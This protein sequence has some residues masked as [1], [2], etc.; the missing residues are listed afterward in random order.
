MTFSVDLRN[1]AIRLYQ[2]TLSMRGV[3]KTLGVSKSSIQRWLSS[4]PFAS[5]RRMVQAANLSVLACIDSRLARNPFLTGHQLAFRIHLET[6]ARVSLSTIY[7]FIKSL[8]LRRKRTSYKPFI[9]AAVLCKR[10]LFAN[11]LLLSDPNS[12]VSVDETAFQ[13]DMFPYA[14]YGESGKRLLAQRKHKAY[15]KRFSVI[16]AVSNSEVVGYKIVFGSVN[17]AVFADFVS[18]LSFKPYH[19]HLLMDNVAFHKTQLVQR[20][21]DQKNVESLFLSPYSPDMNLIELV[22]SKMKNFY[23]RL[24]DGDVFSRVERSLG[25]ECSLNSFFSH[26]WSVAAALTS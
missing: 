4:S 19:T 22:F 12:V 15:C 21:L 25:V 11:R 26:C 17:S 23:R 8:G 3:A 24:A 7:R 10:E 9:D 6:G 16:A 20:A 13:F 2:K 1:A 14:G 5:R 18:S